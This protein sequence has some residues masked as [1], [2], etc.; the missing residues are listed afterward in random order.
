MA[1]AGGTAGI[2]VLSAVALLVAMAD[3]LPV[4]PNTWELFFG[5]EVGSEGFALIIS[6]VRA[7]GGGDGH[8]GLGKATG[9]GGGGGGVRF[10][11]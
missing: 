6:L 9:F 1:W 11:G 7:L 10:C 3:A 8:H 4:A 5:G 2:A